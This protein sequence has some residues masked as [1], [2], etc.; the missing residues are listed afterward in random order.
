MRRWIKDFIHNCIIHP[1]LPFMP[2]RVADLIHDRNADWAFSQ[3]RF[4]ERVIEHRMAKAAIDG[5]D[6][7]MV[8]TME[9]APTGRIPV[10]LDGV[11]EADLR[12]EPDEMRP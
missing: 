6:D 3:E 9:S 1:M 2:V 12:L 11:P 10:V 7:E 5:P 8:P 4:D